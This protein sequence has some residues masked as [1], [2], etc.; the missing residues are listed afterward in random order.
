LGDLGHPLSDKDLKKIGPVDV[1]MIPVGGVYA[2]NGSDAREVVAQLKPR[3]YI[4]PMHYGTKEFQDLLPPDEFLEEQ[5][6]VKDLRD[7][8]PKKSPRVYS[9]ELVVETNFKP[10]E[11]VIVLLNW[12]PMK[13][14]G[15]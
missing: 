7:P 4:I 2:L 11:P 5:Q 10:P 9:N 12:Q 8:G 3:Q 1:L 13:K 15:P 6:H 14:T